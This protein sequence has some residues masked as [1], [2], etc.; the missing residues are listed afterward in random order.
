[1]NREF[2]ERNRKFVDEMYGKCQDILRSEIIPDAVKT[3]MCI[4]EMAGFFGYTSVVQFLKN[5]N[6][7]E[8]S[9]M[10]D[11]FDDATREKLDKLY[12]DVF[13]P[14]SDN[15]TAAFEK[16]EKMLDA[17]EIPLNVIAAYSAQEDDGDD[18]DEEAFDAVIDQLNDFLFDGEDIREI[19]DE[20]EA[21]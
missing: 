13:V 7:P 15:L 21:G 5:I 19:F 3:V 4:K 1:M 11:S 12:D 16:G 10:L 8:V 14:T 20:E 2:I 6:S 9:G 18:F 17:T